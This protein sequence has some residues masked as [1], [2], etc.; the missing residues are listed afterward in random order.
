MKRYIPGFFAP[1]WGSPALIFLTALFICGAVVGSFTGLEYAPGFP[2]YM[3]GP[4]AEIVGSI[5]ELR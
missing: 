5:C 2:S 3:R 4:C 1:I